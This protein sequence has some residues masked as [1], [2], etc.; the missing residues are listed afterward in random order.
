MPRLLV[1]NPGHEEALAHAC[2]PSYTPRREVQRMML[3]LGHLMLLI[4]HEGDYVALPCAGGGLTII[5]YLG[6]EVSP[7]TLPPL[8]LSPWALERHAIT[9]FHKKA[10]ALG[11][12]LRLPPITEPYLAL[13]H[14]ESSTRL[15]RY[16]AEQGWVERTLI[17]EWVTDGPNVAE[18]LTESLDRFA[19]LGHRRLMT[20]RPYSSSGRGVM[21][22]DLPAGDASRIMLTAQCRRWGS[23]SLEPWL[24]IEQDWAIE[25]YYTP[26]E[27]R[28]VGLSRFD[29][30]LGHGAYEGNRLASEAELRANLLQYIGQEAW[31]WL[32]ST[33]CAFLRAE[34]G[35]GYTGYVGVDMCLYRTEAGLSLHPAVEINLRC[36]MGVLAHEA[37]LRH[38]AP[39]RTTRGDGLVQAPRYVF[40][41]DYLAT[42]GT[43]LALY[44]AH[45]AAADAAIPPIPLTKPTIESQYY[46]YLTPDI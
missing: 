27:V 17:P 45:R 32:C 37:Y 4:C 5:D 46:A 41:L 13:S 36:T 44:E 3:D 7:H 2:S 33:H 39:L 12:R 34:L 19:A 22:L 8:E 1:F 6:R 24:T 10:T 15:M 42:S 40:R 23:I 35:A 9:S 18:R 21:P 14:R 20:K 11:I 29:T 26:E 38:V 25:Y 31:E 16:L 30:R 43:A 28:Y